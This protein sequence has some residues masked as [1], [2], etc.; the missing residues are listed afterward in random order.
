MQEVIGTTGPT[1]FLSRILRN[2]ARLAL[3]PQRSRSIPYQPHIRYGVRCRPYAFCKSVR[4]FLG[5]ALACEST[6]VADETRIW[7]RVRFAVSLA[8]LASLIAL[9]ALLAFSKA[10]FS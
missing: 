6:V 7:F 3:S 9:C 5:A 4:A 1:V 2:R 8:K 10:T